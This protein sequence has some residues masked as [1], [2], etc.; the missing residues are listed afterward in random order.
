MALKN[1][2]AAAV[3]LSLL[4]ACGGSSEPNEQ[5][6]ESEQGDAGSSGTSTPS[7]SKPAKADSGSVR[8][9]PDA[10]SDQPTGTDEPESDGGTSSQPS[11]PSGSD[12]GSSDPGTPVKYDYEKQTVKVDKTLEI[13]AGKTVRVGPGTTFAVTGADTQIHVVGTLIV[14]GSDSSLVN[15]SGGDPR[16]W[17]GIVVEKGGNLKLTHAKIGGAAYGIWAMPG[18]DFTVD[19]TEIGT[20]F[21]AAII[22]SN[23]SFAHTKF[24]ATTPDSISL[25]SEVS[26]DDPNG[27]LTIMDASPSV[28][29]SQFD[30]SSGFT[31]MVRIGGNSS[32]TFDH[33]YLHSAHCGFHTSGGTNTSAHITNSIFEDLAYGIMAYA[34][35]PIVEDSV[36]LKNTTDIG[37]CTGATKDNGP[38]LKNNNYTGGEAQ[39]DA[40]CFDITPADPSPAK[41]ANPSAGPS[42]L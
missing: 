5:D 2:H 17:H 39:I 29:N 26:V 25:A 21:K 27:T 34:T 4:S 9:K 40:T 24:E 35:K 28:T 12:A 38:V 30:G 37:M 42:G 6:Q 20:S 18:S 7:S 16:S 36:F 15:F 13:P 3:V 11:Q 31:D 22:Q 41:T 32:P 23:G 14:E 19:Y 8:A 33:V 10:S 1:V